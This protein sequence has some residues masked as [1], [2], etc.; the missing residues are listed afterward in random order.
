MKMIIRSMSLYIDVNSTLQNK[1]NCVSR[2]REKI[3]KS[4]FICD[5]VDDYD[6]TCSVEI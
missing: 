2:P 5:R 6:F 1:E 4:T 3:D